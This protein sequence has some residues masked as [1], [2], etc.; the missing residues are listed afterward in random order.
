VAQLPRED[1]ATVEGRVF[2]ALQSL[3]GE[4]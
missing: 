4:R 2:A 1:G 3:A